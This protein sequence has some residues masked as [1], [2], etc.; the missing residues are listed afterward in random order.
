[1]TLDSGSND[2]LTTVVFSGQLA[3]NSG[4][5]ISISGNDFSKVGAQGIVATGDPNAT[6]NLEYDYWGTTVPSQ[7]EAK[8]LDHSTD[9]TRPTV[10][11]QPYVSFT[12][13]TVASPASE[14]YSPSNQALNLSATVTDSAGITINEGTETFTILNGTQVIGVPTSVTVTNGAASAMYTLPGNTL[15]GKYI[16]EAS[17]SGSGSDYLPSIDTSHT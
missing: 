16:I 8:I 7:I 10:N 3:I 12:S 14:T 13:G 2:T 4:A 9:P 6:I 11:Y 15:P 17:Y 5:T 1:M